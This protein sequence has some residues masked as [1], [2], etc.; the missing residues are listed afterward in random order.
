MSLCDLLKSRRSIYQLGKDIPVSDGELVDFFNSVTE[1]IP[2]AFS[3][4]S[5]RIV[6]ALG[7][8]QDELW[9]AVYDVFGG[10]VS[11]DKID[12]FKAGHGTVLYFYDSEVV[13][14]TME[15]YPRYAKSF[16]EWVQQSNGM[17]Q[18]AVWT[19][20]KEMGIG[21][22]IQHYNPVI[23]EAVKKL[24]DIPESWFLVAQMPFG[25]INFTPMEKEKEDISKRVL[26]KY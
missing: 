26:I 2:D 15:L 5:Q 4:K 25:S 9:D 12:L 7:E 22:N 16:P 24:F 19:G 20:L 3:M 23:D 8:K 18:L 10:K 17:L 11:R 6:V 13:K 21:A 14:K 1:A